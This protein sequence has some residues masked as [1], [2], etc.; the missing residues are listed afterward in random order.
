MKHRFLYLLPLLFCM[1]SQAQR[2]ELLPYADFEQWAVRYIKESAIIGGKTAVLYAVAPTDTI[3]QNAPFT[4][5]TD[6]NIWSPSNAY[7]KVM[8]VEKGSG[9]V[10]PEY[11]DEQHGWCCRMDNKLEV[12]RALGMFDLRVLVAGTLFTGRTIE[13]IRTQKDPYQNIDFGVPFTGHPT[14]LMFDYKALISADRTI[15][16]AKGGIGKPKVTDGH[17]EAHAYIVL[18][19]RWEDSEGN[20]FAER[21]ATGYERFTHDVKQWVNDHTLP[22]HYGDITGTNLYSRYEAELRL[23]DMRRAMNTKGRIVP[24]QETGW[25]KEGTQPTH[26]LINLSSGSYEAFV[27]HDGNTFWVDNIRLVYE[28]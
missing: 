21:V 10:R 11:R 8:G 27:G 14:A 17:D 2:T 22:L 3:R 18:Q 13:P 9:T 5:G 20:I 15:L 24:I 12:V 16:F 7:A 19:R 1:S 4:Y 23:G 26:I 6:G 28:D 25:A